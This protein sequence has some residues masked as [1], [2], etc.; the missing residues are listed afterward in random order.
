MF[1]F[2]KEIAQTQKAKFG[3]LCQVI[4]D[5]RTFNIEVKFLNI[6]LPCLILNVFDVL[7]YRVQLFTDTNEFF[8]MFDDK[9]LHNSLYCCYSRFDFC[10]STNT[11][12]ANSFCQTALSKLIWKW[13]DMAYGINIRETALK[14]Q[15]K[16]EFTNLEAFNNDGIPLLLKCCKSPKIKLCASVHKIILLLPK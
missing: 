12:I 1:L 9:I 15:E 5:T 16:Q 4:L 3:E 2:S 10:L 13:N 6:I 7:L 8:F 14:P 11:R